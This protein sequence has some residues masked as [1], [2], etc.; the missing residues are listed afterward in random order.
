M[1][2]HRIYIYAP[3]AG[4][5]P[6][7]L[8]QALAQG[9]QLRQGVGRQEVPEPLLSMAKQLEDYAL[10]LSEGA[11][12][13]DDSEEEAMVSDLQDLL[14]GLK[15]RL[16]EKGAPVIS[17]Q[18]PV[19]GWE[20]FLWITVGLANPLGLVVVD[21][22]MMMAFLPNGKV[23]PESREADWKSISEGFRSE[24]A[25]I[26]KEENLPRTARQYITWSRPMYEEYLHGNGFVKVGGYYV[27]ECGLVKIRVLFNYQMRYPLFVGLYGLTLHSQLVSDMAAKFGFVTDENVIFVITLPDQAG[28]EYSSRPS[29][30][31]AAVKW[32]IDMFD[33]FVMKVLGGVHDILTLDKVMNEPIEISER[34]KLVLHNK[35]IPYRLIVA[36]LAG[37]RAGHGLGRKVL[38]PQFGGRCVVGG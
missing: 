30:S 20:H 2:I 25:E 8:E 21:D 37:R 32:E 10:G 3:V 16:A 18:M 34:S 12:E 28:E 38:H 17:F 19:E 9:E 4:V 26:E 11:E 22:A 23:Y 13:D 36:R 33:R 14:G 29:I 35:Y 24:Q 31:C 1:N 5:P 6:V 15:D 7:D 27:K